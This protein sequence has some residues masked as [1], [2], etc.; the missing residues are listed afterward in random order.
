MYT[1]KEYSI[2]LNI[3]VKIRTISS[4]HTVYINIGTYVNKVY[5]ISKYISGN[6]QYISS[7]FMYILKYNPPPLPFRATS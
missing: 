2:Y 6:T 3:L 1:N 5:S 4:M 7:I